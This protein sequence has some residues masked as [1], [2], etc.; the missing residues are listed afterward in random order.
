MVSLCDKCVVH[1][2]DEC[3]VNVCDERVVNVCDE[4]V[5]HVLCVTYRTG[6]VHWATLRR[7]ATWR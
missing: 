5:V 6:P 4:C 3:V 1:I 7:G 2:C